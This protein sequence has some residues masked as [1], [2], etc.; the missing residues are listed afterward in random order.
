M[1]VYAGT[2]LEK[3]AQKLVLLHEEDTELRLM[4]RG[5]KKI[6][7]EE[8]VYVSDK[9]LEDINK[10]IPIPIPTPVSVPTPVKRE[11][12]DKQ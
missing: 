8:P 9:Q 11:D 6:Q 10:S 1:R 2:P 7:K 4:E 3:M 12:N 5:K